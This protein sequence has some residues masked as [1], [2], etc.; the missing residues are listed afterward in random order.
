MRNRIRKY[1]LDLKGQQF[2]GNQ[3]GLWPNKLVFW[4]LCT[5]LLV[6]I[7]LIY[8]L[9]NFREYPLHAKFDDIQCHDAIH[10]KSGRGRAAHVQIF[11][12]SGEEVIIRGNF[13]GSSGILYIDRMD[14][15][16]RLYHICFVR[17][18]DVFLDDN[19]RLVGLWRQDSNSKGVLN[20]GLIESRISNFNNFFKRVIEVIFYPILFIVC[21]VIA[22]D[23]FFKIIFSVSF[24]Q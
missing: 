10:V 19:S 18:Q 2:L 12:V 1:L 16:D 23:I 20:R 13:A 17:L 4:L 9:I 8:I 15:R 11:D 21:F 3:G 22:V 14:E 6:T 5:S 24:F 7:I